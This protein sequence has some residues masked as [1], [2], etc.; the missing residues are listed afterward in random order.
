MKILIEKID[1]TRILTAVIFHLCIDEKK[2]KDVFEINE[3]D[4]EII[5]KKLQEFIR[6][7]GKKENIIRLWGYNPQ[8]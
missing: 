5:I 3:K 6:I 8:S 2:A 1:K 4:Y 7:N